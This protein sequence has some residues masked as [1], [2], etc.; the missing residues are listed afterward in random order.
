MKTNNNM[1]PV[2]ITLGITLLIGASVRIIAPSN[3]VSK[4]SAFIQEEAGET[5]FP[6]V[7]IEAV[8]AIVVEYPSM[9][10][11]YQKDPGIKRPLASITKLM[12]ALSYRELIGKQDSIS[13]PVR[14]ALDDIEVE[15]DSGFLAGEEFLADDLSDIMLLNSSNDAAHALA[16]SVGRYFLSDHLSSQGEARGED[17]RSVFLEEMNRRSGLL[18]LENTFFMSES[19]LDIS[20]TESGAYGTAWDVAKLTAYIMS[21][22][23]DLV[24]I[25][26]SEE[27]EVASLSGRTRSYKNTNLLAGAMPGLIASKT[28]FS[29]L[30]GGNLVIVSD[31]G[32]QKPVII[33]VL[34]SSLAGRFNDVHKLYLA[35]KQYYQ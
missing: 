21:H 3:Y 20:E 30:A 18:G 27:I 12:T 34:G 1:R 8:S 31:V 26:V 22:Y 17:P 29:N 24:R 28:G 23:P 14:I 4:T 13:F 10:R 19:G 33:V 5:I 6:E 7:E 9:R 15:G 32:F 25:T 16:S 35:T 11:I 2:F